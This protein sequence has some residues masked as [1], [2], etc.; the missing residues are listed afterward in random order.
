MSGDDS[1]AGRLTGEG[2]EGV[3]GEEL[4]AEAEEVAVVPVG[5]AGA[6]GGS[7]GNLGRRRPAEI[8]PSATPC[9]YWYACSKLTVLL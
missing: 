8:V 2:K 1:S 9:L 7:V 6:V 4:S 5:A 3:E